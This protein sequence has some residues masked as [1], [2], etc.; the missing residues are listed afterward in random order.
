M[1]ELPVINE[2]YGGLST[3]E[4]VERRTRDLISIGF[5]D[6]LIDEDA[7]FFTENTITYNEIAEVEEKFVICFGPA[8]LYYLGK[9][10]DT[11]EEGHPVGATWYNSD[12]PPQFKSTRL[13]Q[14]LPTDRTII[15]YS[16]GGHNS[17]MATAHLGLL[18]YNVRSVLF[19]A[20]NIFYSR[21]LCNLSFTNLVFTNNSRKNYTYITDQ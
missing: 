7:S 14:T 17:A 5:R 12:P 6:I 21:L 3:K 2:S 19:G 16:I 13:L 1:K 11:F 18:G 20:H 8:G 15:I 4:I 10:G 9:Q